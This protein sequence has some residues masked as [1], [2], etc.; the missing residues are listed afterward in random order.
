MIDGYKKKAE[1]SYE[2]VQQ[3]LA[4]SAA[5]E[6]ESMSLIAFIELFLLV[7]VLFCC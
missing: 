4:E 5:R 3:V 6:M 2:R 1:E 7:L